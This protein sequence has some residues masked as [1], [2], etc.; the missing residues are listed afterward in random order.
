MTTAIETKEL[1]FSYPADEGDF[2]LP[3][4]E[5]LDLTIEEG[6]FVAVL[7]HNG[8]GKSTLAKHFNAVLLPEGGNVYVYG[9]DSADEEQLIEIRRTVGMVFQ[10]PD[11]QMVANV[12]EEDVAFAPE[13][14]GVEPGEIRRR[15]DEALKT[16]GMYD[17]RMHAPH[18][19]SS[20]Q[21]QRVAIAGVIAMRPKCIVLDEPTAMLDPHGR[22][23]VIST[24]ERLNK[25]SGITVILITHHMTEACRADRVIVMQEGRILTD[26]SPREVFSQVELLKSADLTVP[27][28]TELLYELNKAG[29][30]LPLDALSTEECAQAL[31][32]MLKA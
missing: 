31:C 21:K 13:N 17:F 22:E 25:E 9:M 2:S 16:V 1:T 3:V 5:K 6:S 32:A 28:T 15:V 10:N 8:C 20:G 14:L 18:L 26:G 27:A 19:L 11:N 29:C 24:I 23:E 7:G 4:F 12:V 30:E